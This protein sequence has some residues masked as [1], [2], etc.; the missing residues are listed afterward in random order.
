MLR[1]ARVPPSRRAS[2]DGSCRRE[3]RAE[4]P[5][6]SRAKRSGYPH[7]QKAV[8]PS[9]RPDRLPRCNTRPAL[10]SP[11]RST[12]EMIAGKLGFA[13]IDARLARLRDFVDEVLERERRDIGHK[14]AVE[15]FPKELHRQLV[16]A[17]QMKLRFP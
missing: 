1:E 4:N 2:T 6:V 11:R 9:F 5:R 7:A 8:R 16:F 15:Q 17:R 10:P 13:L 14:R 3:S 12:V